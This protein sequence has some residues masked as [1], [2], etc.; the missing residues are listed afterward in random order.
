MNIYELHLQK[1]L[2]VLSVMP[3]A[4]D[5]Y[6]L[7]YYMLNLQGVPGSGKFMEQAPTPLGS[8]FPYVSLSGIQVYRLRNVPF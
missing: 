7:Y 8:S 3:L 1:D 6:V 5:T 4:D 2:G